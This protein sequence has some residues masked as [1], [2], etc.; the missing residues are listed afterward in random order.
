MASLA[1]SE[2]LILCCGSVQTRQLRLPCCGATRQFGWLAQKR[3]WE[4]QREAAVRDDRGRGQADNGL[5]HAPHTSITTST[6]SHL[7]WLLYSRCILST[8]THRSATRSSAAYPPSNTQVARWRSFPPSKLGHPPS[9]P[10]SR[11]A[12]S[13]TTDKL[14]HSP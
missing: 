1:E 14:S 8:Y 9:D 10:S 12:A 13:T 3:L 11:S 4:A 5:L 6:S 2:R 7:L